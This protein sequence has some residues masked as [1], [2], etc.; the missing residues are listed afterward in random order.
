MKYIYGSCFT[1]KNLGREIILL[2]H[3]IKKIASKSEKV[4]IFKSNLM[5]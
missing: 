2:K 5:F 1:P 3:F 4:P